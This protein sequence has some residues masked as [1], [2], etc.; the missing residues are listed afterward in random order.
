MFLTA[1]VVVTGTLTAYSKYR[2]DKAEIEQEKMN[3]DALERQ[4][5]YAEIASRRAEEQYKRESGQIIGAISGAV[6]HSGFDFSGSD[7]QLI[8]ESLVNQARKLEDIKAEGRYHATMI[9]TGKVS[10]SSRIS[11][12]KRGV[13]YGLASS[14]L[15]TGTQAYTTYKAGKK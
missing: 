8:E 2:A 12:I 1:A 6:Q 4:A 11:G 3:I 5:Q 14:A 15:S 13:K 7:Y 9:R 10:A